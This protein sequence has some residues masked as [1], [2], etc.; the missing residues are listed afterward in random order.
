ML[1]RKKYGEL[2]PEIENPWLTD[3]CR[4]AR[5]VWFGRKRK[6]IGWLNLVFHPHDLVEY[7]NIAG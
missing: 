3:F 6:Q 1:L 5:R 7:G 2:S 4:L